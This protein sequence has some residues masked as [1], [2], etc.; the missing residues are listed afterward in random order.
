MQTFQARLTTELQRALAAADLPPAGE[1]TPATDARF[2]DY[3][4][5]AAL[6]LAKQR[7]ENPRQLAQK[8]IDHLALG[9]LAQPPTIAGPGFI[10]FT[11][12]GD[13]IAAQAAQLLRDDRLG[14]PRAE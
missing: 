9:E 12:K 3:Q 1:V 8:I 2:G 10:N 11:L 6:I 4:T 14:V 5:N 7:G 13:A